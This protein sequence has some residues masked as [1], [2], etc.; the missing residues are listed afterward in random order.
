MLGEK[1]L[2]R[3]NYV[4]D[5][6]LAAVII[7]CICVGSHKGAIRT[8]ISVAGYIAAF[9]AAVFV[10]NVADEYIYDSF[11]RPAVMS[12]METK[13]DE[14]AEEYSSAE[15]LGRLLSENGI[16]VD[17]E[18]L[19][20]I[21]NNG[22]EYIGVLTNEEF[23]GKLNNVFIGYCRLLTE[24]FAGII[25]EEIASEAERYI[26]NADEKNSVREKIIT[27]ERLSVTEI[28]EKEIVRPVMLK[29]VNTVLFAVTFAAVSLLVSIISKAA[30]AVRKIPALRSADGYAGG[31][32]GF[33]QG[34]FIGFALCAASNVFIKLT[35]DGYPQFN[36]EIIS[37]T[38]IFKGFYGGTM[39]LL[40]ILLK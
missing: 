33:F 29:T 11:V 17:D 19:E 27:A 14:L 7:I 30:A 1:G 31:L 23:R 5:I 6:V 37:Q 39:L 26:E 35:A 2:N 38:Y 12:A 8:L 4:L 36:T 21:L 3:L 40:S 20:A 15:G 34:I 22:E 13:A 9:A 10:S 32:L 25:P 24:T 16:E 18:Q 28:I